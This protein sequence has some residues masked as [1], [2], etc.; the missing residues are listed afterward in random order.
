MEMLKKKWCTC[1]MHKVRLKSRLANCPDTSRRG[2]T[3][4]AMMLAAAG[5]CLCA[6]SWAAAW[7]GSAVCQ[8]LLCNGK[9]H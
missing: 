7:S 8:L 3:F 2:V 5:V 9:S 1:A 4:S 6:C